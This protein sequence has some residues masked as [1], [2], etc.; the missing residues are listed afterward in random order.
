[1]TAELAFSTSRSDWSLFGHPATPL[2]GVA[3]INV[4]QFFFPADHG[5]RVHFAVIHLHTFTYKCAPGTEPD[6]RPYIQKMHT[7]KLHSEKYK[8]RTVQ[9]QIV[10]NTVYVSICSNVP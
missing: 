7:K 2:V 4:S 5:N 10:K 6:S 3:L 1:M 9:I 8:R